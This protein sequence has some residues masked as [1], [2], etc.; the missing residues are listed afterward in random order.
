MIIKNQ[1]IKK[2]LNDQKV[3]FA[4]VHWF[5]EKKII[6]VNYVN[7]VFIFYIEKDVSSI[8]IYLSK[9][10]KFIINIITKYKY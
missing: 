10:I 5:S 8:I 6:K 3:V 7:V 9:I 4:I 2:Y 1:F